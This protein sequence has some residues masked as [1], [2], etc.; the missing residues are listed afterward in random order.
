MLNHFHSLDSI[1]F[2]HRALWQLSLYNHLDYPWRDALPSLCDWLDGM[3]DEQLAVYQKDPYQ[4]AK[5]IAP[6][7]TEAEELYALTQIPAAPQHGISAPRGIDSGIPGRKWQQ[8]ESF[9]ASIENETNDWLEWCAGKGYLGRLLTV[10]QSNPAVTSLEWQSALCLDGQAY[11][12]AHQLNM[13]FIQADALSR[14]SQQYVKQDQ[15]AVA[16]HACGE[17]HTQLL[18]SAVTAST[19]QVSISP[20]CYHLISGDQYQALSCSAQSAKLRLNKRDLRLPLQETVTAGKR[21]QRHRILEVSY[22]L[23][24]D[25][26]QRSL[27]SHSEYMPVPSIKKSLLAN[28][29]EAF[30]MW[31]ANQKEITLPDGIDFDYWLAQGRQRV[32]LVNRMDLVQLAFKRPLEMWLVLDRALYLQESGYH[33]KVAT[34]CQ[35]QCTPRNI[36]IS[37]NRSE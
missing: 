21:T 14:G 20:C 1:L 11:A 2:K 4:L 31:A 37:A 25:S 29:F 10:Q 30:C 35:R 24:F 9:V 19:K 26:L 22:R 33:V 15:H 34:F 3:S 13:S 5:A 6:W 12:D 27:L 32:T 17:L 23:G 7:I 28:G 16:L 8:I 18:H 36:I